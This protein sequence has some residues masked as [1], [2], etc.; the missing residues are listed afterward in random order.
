MESRWLHKNDDMPDDATVVKI[1]S[2]S[3]SNIN[4]DMKIVVIGGSGLIGRKLVNTFGKMVM[5][6]W[7]PHLLPASTPSLVK[8]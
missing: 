2:S 4:K 3:T 8:D 7:R 5:R 6:S 1:K